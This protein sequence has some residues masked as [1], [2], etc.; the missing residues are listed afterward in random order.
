MTIYSK[1]AK[2]MREAS[3]KTK[4]LSREL[5]TLLKLVNGKATLEELRAQLADSDQDAL[6]PCI[7]SLVKEDYIHVVEHV[8]LEPRAPPLAAKPT[9]KAPAAKPIPAPA[10]DE[11]GGDLDFFAAPAAAPPPVT[12]KVPPVAPN[13]QEA[14]AI[15]AKRAAAE[16][17]EKARAAAQEKLQQA[18]QAQQRAAAEAKI[19]LEAEEKAKREMQEKLAREAEEKAKQAA[20]AAAQKRDAEDAAKRAAQ[21]KIERELQARQRAEADAA[22]AAAA[23]AASAAAARAAAEEKVHREAAEIARRETEELAKREAAERL[24]LEA[25]AKA[26]QAFEEKARRLAEE[27]AVREAQEQAQRQEVERLRIE[28]E[29]LRA[30][31]ARQRIENAARAALEAEEK[32]KRAAEEKVRREAAERIQAEVTEQRRLAAAAQAEL[33]AQVK[34]RRDAEEKVQREVAERVRLEAEA[35]AKV[36]AEAQARRDAEARVKRDAQEKIEREAE[37]KRRAEAEAIA[38]RE[39]DEKAR[40][41]AEKKARAE[42]EANA[43]RSE[44]EKQ[45]H[46]DEEHARE[47]AQG[48]AKREAEEHAR[49]EAE[50][51]KWRAEEQE[52]REAEAQLEK[53][54]IHRET[55]EVVDRSASAA[56]GKRSHQSPNWAKRIVMALVFLVIVGAGLIHVLPFN[57][58][59]AIFEKLASAQFSQPVTIKS[60]HAALMPKP[61]WRAEGVS[62]GEGGQIRIDAINA[63]SSIGGLLGSDGGINSLDLDTVTITEQGLGLLLSGKV[64]QVTLAL[65]KL[66]AKNVKFSSPLLQVP[67]TDVSLEVAADGNWQK[68]TAQSADKKFLVEF[69]ASADGTQIKLDAAGYA[70]PLGLT[71]E[72]VGKAAGASLS[73]FRAVGKLTGS[74]LA[75]SAFSGG[76]FEGVVEGKANVTWADELRVAGEIETKRIGANVLMP[77]LFETGILSSRGGFTMNGADSA[78]LEKSVRLDGNFLIERGELRR[79]DLG[80]ILQGGGSS[81]KTAFATLVGRYFYTEGKTLTRDVKLGAAILTANG[82]AE[83]SAEKK[84]SGKFAVELKSAQL[85]VK[86]NLNVSGPLSEPQ[87]SR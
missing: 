60:L 55:A 32:A 15:A 4:N 40:L 73:D 84:L 79:V 63:G 30:E 74:Q 50:E 48:Q 25:G 18:A 12:P 56:S 64:G 80:K 26:K 5:R 33:D 19:R 11:D 68:I 43:L 70:P 47:L 85:T 8:E 76:V 69:E 17:E 59:K 3:G 66:S 71:P 75:V 9:A 62:V 7:V 67:I 36:E 81:G 46:A 16:A 72:A 77:T 14:Q 35:K 37:E 38:K 29:R 1:T 52:R 41:A 87:F 22:A 65:P 13:N 54:H 45:R 86:G 58:Q 44:E 53:E 31:V 28:T 23:S 42:A 6:E 61:H 34:L 51:A 10:A 24:R 82:N 83:L 27:K 57:G 49:R 2:G 39:A 20:A 78:T 21:E